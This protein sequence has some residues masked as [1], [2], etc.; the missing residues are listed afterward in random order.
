MIEIVHATK[1][2]ALP[3]AK[4]WQ[5]IAQIGGLERDVPSSPTHQELAHE[6]Q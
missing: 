6:H 4:A 3:S 5:A 2:I 1:I